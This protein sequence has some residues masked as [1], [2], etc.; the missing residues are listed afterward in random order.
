MSKVA[1]DDPNAFPCTIKYTSVSGYTPEYLAAKG[2]VNHDSCTVSNGVKV[3]YFTDGEPSGVPVIC[4]HGGS[5]GKYMWLQKEPLPG[6]YM[7]AIDRPGY[8][9]SDDPAGKIP[10]Y[11]FEMIAKD[12]GMLA[13]H[14][15]IDKFILLGFSIGTS[16]AQQIACV[17]T[18]RVRGLILFG[19]MADSNHPKMTA[20][21]SKKVGKPPK[22]M[23][24]N[25]GCLGFVLRGAFSGPIK[26]FGKYDLSPKMDPDAK[27]KEC[28]PRFKEWTSDPFWV[29]VAV[30]D[31][32][33]FTKPFG[34]IG[35]AYRSLFQ[36]W[37][38]DVAN[39]KCPV[40]NFQGEFDNDMG[41]S[42]PHS[43]EFL[44]QMVPHAVIE[45][46]PGC[47]HASTVG[48]DE[49]TRSRI[50]KAVEAIMAK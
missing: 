45:F 24:P 40:Y 29:C 47:G 19:C 35:D 14:L 39:I 23:D 9:D 50:L 49:G 25:G 38:Y 31:A 30:D 11:P 48:P 1:P 46:I 12:I 7:I 5:Q 34:Q 41:S 21:L 17:L 2:R 27:R 22:V 43:S 3:T 18:E 6:V 28:E 8:G 15:K 10:D 20:K 44:Q 32:R 42:A 36:P 4:L 26:Q 37:Q 33:A 13:D 16:W